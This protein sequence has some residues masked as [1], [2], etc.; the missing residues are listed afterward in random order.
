MLRRAWTETRLTGSLHSPKH[1]YIRLAVRRQPSGNQPVANI[2]V[3]AKLK[4]A[5]VVA[6][7]HIWSLNSAERKCSFDLRVEQ[8]SAFLADGSVSAKQFDRSYRRNELPLGHRLRTNALSSSVEKL[9]NNP[10]SRSRRRCGWSEVVARA[11]SRSPAGP[12]M[13]ARSP[14]LSPDALCDGFTRSAPAA[15]KFFSFGRGGIV[16]A[17]R[18][19]SL[20]Q[21]RQRRELA[22][23]RSRPEFDSL[24]IPL[25]GAL[26]VG[27]GTDGA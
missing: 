6:N 22:G 4:R 23:G 3:R 13:P 14:R 7:V 11:W 21:L 27:F 25:A 24:L 9:G 2:G 8:L 26:D 18:P 1:N 10:S 15:A 19:R 12:C 5:V 20:G 17:N 16:A